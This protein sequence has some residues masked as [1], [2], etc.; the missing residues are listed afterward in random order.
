MKKRGVKQWRRLALKRMGPYLRR[1]GE[2]ASLWSQ[3]EFRIDFTV[4]ELLKTEQQ[5]S[6]CVTSQLGFPQKL[7]A[8]KALIAVIDRGQLH[9]NL[10][11]TLNKFSADAT[12]KY[13][14]RNRA[15]HDAWTLGVRS[16]RVSQ[17]TATIKDNRLRFG[18]TSTTIKDLDN[19]TATIRALLRRVH[20]LECSILGAFAPSPHKY[21]LGYFRRTS[22]KSRRADRQANSLGKR[23]A[24]REASPT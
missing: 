13:D 12:A 23:V 16:R 5:Y 21:E 18:P 19:T 22:P 7:R 15:V 24:R 1:V 10:I 8:L 17:Y 3:V 11:K 6:A 4:W 2:I 14:L 9:E 20:R